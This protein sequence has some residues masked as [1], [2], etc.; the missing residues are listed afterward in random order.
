MRSMTNIE[1]KVGSTRCFTTDIGQLTAW[2][3]TGDSCVQIVKLQ[4][5]GYL[6]MNAEVSQVLLV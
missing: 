4:D 3:P 6:L 2:R 5:R 1:H